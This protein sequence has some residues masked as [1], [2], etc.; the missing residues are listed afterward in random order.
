MSWT[1]KEMDKLF[2]KEAG[3]QSFEYK[4]A[5]WKEMEAMLPVAK[6]GD[7]LWFLTSVC[8]ICPIR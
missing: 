2:Q 5:Y 1:D 6:K 4:D 3:K 8:W 7:F